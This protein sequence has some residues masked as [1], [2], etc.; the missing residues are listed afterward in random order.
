LFIHGATSRLYLYT[1]KFIK[2]P[3]LV[4]LGPLPP[5]P[6]PHRS[7]AAAPAASTFARPFNALQA[8]SLTRVFVLLP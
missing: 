6:E 4:L 2:Y 8:L 3:L 1:V 5:N 7:S